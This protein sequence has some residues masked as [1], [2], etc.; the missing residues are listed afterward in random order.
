[1]S[2]GRYF[3]AG[4][5]TF[6]KQIFTDP[7]HPARSTLTAYVTSAGTDHVDLCLPYG[8]DAAHGYPFAP[9]MRFELS[10]E[11]RGM[12]LR[13][14]A[15]FL[16]RT[17]SN[18]IRLRFEGDLEFTSLRQ[19]RR[20]DVNAWA[21]LNRSGG[22]LAEMRAAWE[23]HLRQLQNGVSAA[24]LTKFAKAQLNL[25]GGGMCLA[26]SPAAKVAELVMV[27]LSI[28]DKGG[29][30]CA[31]AEV[32]WAG[33]TGSDGS[34][35]VGMRFLNILAEDQSR[36]DRVVTSLLKRLEEDGT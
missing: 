26:V 27:F 33:E 16:E 24:K 23:E 2:Y 20:V 18:G 32:V 6:L 19:F 17:G 21:G 30:I 4:Q 34:Q 14:L 31:L 8:T 11:T 22:S 36:I 25:S 1:M 9:G 7:A 12:G 15:S 10:S 28:G 5:K 35:P 13:L 29:I 3:P